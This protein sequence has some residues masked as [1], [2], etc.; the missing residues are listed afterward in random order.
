MPAAGEKNREGS[1]QQHGKKLL[2]DRRA[3]ADKAEDGERQ[4]PEC[5]AIE[6]G[7]GEIENVARM[8]EAELGT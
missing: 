7:G 1:E 2:P 8:E 5:G 6:N 4:E 3:G